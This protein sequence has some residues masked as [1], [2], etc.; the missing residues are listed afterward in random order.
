MRML[1]TWLA[2]HKCDERGQL[3]SISGLFDELIQAG[4]DPLDAVRTVV[5]LL[6]GEQRV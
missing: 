1:L 6:A 4:E 3:S 2:G 5:S